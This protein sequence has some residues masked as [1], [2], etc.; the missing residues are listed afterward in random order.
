MSMYFIYRCIRLSTKY[1]NILFII[2]YI[3]I[4]HIHGYC[5]I[6]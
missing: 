1:V 5:Y 3:Y 2:M 4:V 6:A